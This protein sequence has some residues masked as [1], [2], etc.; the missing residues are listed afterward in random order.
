[1][2]PDIRLRVSVMGLFIQSDKVLM[3]HKMTGPEVDCWDL[4]G[5]GIQPGEP[6]M[7]ALQRE[8]QEETGLTDFRVQSL[9]TVVE[10][11]YPN[12]QSQ[13]LHSLSIIYICAVDG[14]PILRTH[15]DREVG[16]RGVQW[17]PVATLTAD[18]CSARSWKAL[19]VAGAIPKG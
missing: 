1:M 14:D 2:Q 7:Q 17:L 13:L 3:I 19:Q 9:L 5:G 15:G 18:A 11:F 6:L 16:S 10:N 12:W 8:I 4:P